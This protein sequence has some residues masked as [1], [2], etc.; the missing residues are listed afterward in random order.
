[1][2]TIASAS[3]RPGSVVTLAIR[4]FAIKQFRVVPVSRH[5]RSARPTF[6]LGQ[7]VRPGFVGSHGVGPVSMG[8]GLAR[9]AA[10]G[11]GRAFFN[12]GPARCCTLQ[13]IVGQRR[14]IPDVMSQDTGRLGQ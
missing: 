5:I 12:V 14:V 9:Y 10:A 13:P 2:R 7:H 8:R 4:Q 3:H 11:Q 1:M 6:R